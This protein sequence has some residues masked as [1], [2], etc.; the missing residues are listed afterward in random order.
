M[1]MR[2]HREDS[3]HYFGGRLMNR[4]WSAILPAVLV[5]GLV[6]LSVVAASPDA[7]ES[8]VAGEMV[9]TDVPATYRLPAVK[10]SA[11]VASAEE[12]AVEAAAPAT[13]AKPTEGS[14]LAGT[15]EEVG[16]LEAADIAMP[17]QNEAVA[18]VNPT[19]A[20][21]GTAAVSE[22]VTPLP[23]NDGLMNTESD[24]P[25]E[26]YMS[27]P[28]TGEPLYGVAVV[29]EV[30]RDAVMAT[31]MVRDAGIVVNNER[32]EG[33]VAQAIVAPTTSELTTQ[34]LPAVQRGFGL[35]QKRAY[36][37]A[38]TEFVQVLRRIAQSHDAAAD[39]DEHAQAL[40]AGL[41]ALD[42]AED[43]VPNGVQLEAELDVRRVASSHRTNVLPDEFEKVTPLEAVTLYH[44]FAQEQLRIAVAGE[45]AGSMVLYGMGTIYAK[46]AQNRDEDAQMIKCAMTMYSA[47]LATCPN[48]YMA[49]NEL[50][51]LAC[52]SGRV[53]EAIGL[54][55]QTI[56]F[57]PSAV[58]YHN[59]AM[60]LQKVG[61]HEAA[62][63]NE[64]ESQRLAMLER[65]R[66]EV[67]R[68]AG[69]QWVT[70]AEMARAGRQEIGTP[71]DMNLAQ[72]L[73]PQPERSTWRKVVD[74]TK[75]LPFPG[76]NSG[77]DALGP[78]PVEQVAEPARVNP[79]RWR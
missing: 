46:L 15:A 20:A 17:D 25:R 72:P 5:T 47:A 56:D 7:E 41:R 74:S 9:D 71:A 60:A 8:R 40:A 13:E 2:N 26:V 70:P 1:T 28:E 18:E 62:A 21:P 27:R 14:A 12:I 69:I 23:S 22:D 33:P 39:T 6:A 45:Q 32:V 10:P 53:D 4:T 24:P 64:V 42:E 19:E 11:D 67:S 29:P 43:F 37:A 73:A 36:F 3:V 31:P 75:S 52:R 63:A 49:A 48:N 77:N 61:Q 50:G 38:R 58:A 68:R 30:R 16:P 54:F 55:Q 35:A 66:G 59:L 44:T 76:K 79:R 51:V 65:S 78:R 34:L 57:A